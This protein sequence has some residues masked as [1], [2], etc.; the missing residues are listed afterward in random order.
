MIER[1]ILHDNILARFSFI[2]RAQNRRISSPQLLQILLGVCIRPRDGDVS[3]CRRD[4]VG[5]DD[6]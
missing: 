1:G 6:R 3:S 2:S 4:V 5:G